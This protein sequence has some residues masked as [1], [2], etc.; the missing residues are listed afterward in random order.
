MIVSPPLQTT[1]D[2]LKRSLEEVKSTKEQVHYNCQDWMDE[3]GEEKLSKDSGCVSRLKDCKDLYVNLGK[4]SRK[5][6]NT[7]KEWNC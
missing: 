3:C 1:C 5:M 7:M 2:G 4:L 6:D